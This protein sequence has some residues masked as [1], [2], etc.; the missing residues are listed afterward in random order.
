MIVAR[1][2]HRADGLELGL[3]AG[4][5]GRVDLVEDDG[6]GE[7]QVDLAG[8]VHEAVAGTVRVGDGDVQVGG[9]EAEV[10]VAAVPEDD[11]GFLL[12][13]AH[14]GLVVDAGV[15][16]VAGHDVRLVLFHLLDGALVLLEVVEGRVALHA[17]GD[18]VAVRHGVTDADDLLAGLAQHGLDLARGLALAGAGAHGADGD[19]RL[20][21]LDH[22]L[23]RAHQHE[24]GAERVHQRRAVHDVLVGHVGVG[25]D[26][27]FDAVLLD[28]LG[29]LGLVVDRDAVRVV[30]TGELGRVLAVVDVRDLRGR[31]GDDLVL[32]P[33]AEVGVEVVEVATRGSHDEDFGSLCH[34]HSCGCRSLR[35]TILVSGRRSEHFVDVR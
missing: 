17:L 31:E 25:E 18:E 15:D 29:H 2:V 4:A 5:V 10:V 9:V 22:D 14:D 13:L 26:D 24:V 20:G 21:A 33:L 12:G 6:V 34:A 35:A 28:E 11:V 8:V 27:D 19:H 23:V 3:D 32:L 16:H 7:P 1:R 30:R